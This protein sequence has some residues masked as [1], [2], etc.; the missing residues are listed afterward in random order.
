[1]K[2]KYA[3]VIKE[4]TKLVEK[5]KE[6][7]EEIDKL[8]PYRIFH[9]FQNIFCNEIPK[10]KKSVIKNIISSGISKNI[11]GYSYK[12]NKERKLFHYLFKP[13]SVEIDYNSR[14]RSYGRVTYSFCE[15]KTIKSF[16]NITKKEDFESFIRVF[17]N[18]LNQCCKKYRKLNL[19]CLKNANGLFLKQIV[20]S[21][22]YDGLDIKKEYKRILNSS[23]YSSDEKIDVLDVI[24]KKEIVSYYNLYKKNSIKFNKKLKRIYTIELISNLDNYKSQKLEQDGLI[25]A[26]DFFFTHDNYWV[27]YNE[28]KKKIPEFLSNLS[29]KE[30]ISIIDYS[31]SLSLNNSLF[32]WGQYGVAPLVSA[33][34]RLVVIDACK[35]LDVDE[36]CL[37][38]MHH[39]NSNGNHMSASL[40]NKIDIL[41]SKEKCIWS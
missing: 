3:D 10:M 29:K 27:L 13:N 9:I 31:I 5:N 7:L 12:M 15:N 25:F 41:L 4:I 28:I 40:Q 33:V 36:D 11:S 19:F 22:F 21:N 8:D 1:M 23:N 18:S 37:Y 32:K 2:N 24:S 38:L 35:Y 30:I 20:H 17:S 26:K 6:K 39:V 16:K 34:L 14:Y